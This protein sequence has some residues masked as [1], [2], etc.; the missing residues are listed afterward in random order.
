MLLM[1]S[2][3]YLQ[4]M[5]FRMLWL[6][7]TLILLLRTYF[8]LKQIVN[9]EMKCPLVIDTFLN[10][11]LFIFVCVKMCFCFQ[12]SIFG[13][14]LLLNFLFILN[15]IFKLSN[16]LLLFHIHSSWHWNIQPVTLWYTSLGTVDKRSEGE[17][18]GSKRLK[19]I[20]INT[21]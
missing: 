12:N 15:V 6:H 4:N 1:Y 14:R 11:K 8:I 16:I 13:I 3:Y 20:Y 2:I 9:F 17:S 5:L 19:G 7:V 10:I 21:K 18:N